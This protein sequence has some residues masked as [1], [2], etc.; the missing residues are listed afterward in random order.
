MS[1]LHPEPRSGFSRE[2]W[3]R[4]V[5]DRLGLDA[6]LYS[7]RRLVAMFIGSLVLIAASG[8][9]IYDAV[10]GA[11]HRYTRYRNPFVEL[12]V[13]PLGIVFF[14]ACCAYLAAAMIAKRHLMSPGVPDPDYNSVDRLLPIHKN[15]AAHGK[16][17]QD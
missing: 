17:P 14:G 16:P 1:E 3:P 15:S 6:R 11:P 13:G 5:H 8:F 10:R 4:R 12:S 9:A 7:W 2:L